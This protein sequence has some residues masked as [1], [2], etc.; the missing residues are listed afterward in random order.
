M[1]A[2]FHRDSFVPS[3]EL[4]NKMRSKLLETIPLIF[5]RIYLKLVTQFPKNATFLRDQISADST[6]T[7]ELTLKTLN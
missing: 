6:Y 4:K 5:C 3:K 2:R 7:L 1:E